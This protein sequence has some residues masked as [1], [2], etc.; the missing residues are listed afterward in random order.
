M[1][2][3][4]SDVTAAAPLWRSGFRPFFLAAASYAVLLMAAWM[5][6]RLGPALGLAYDTPAWHGHEAIFGFV[7]ATTAGFLL[8]ALPSWA[9]TPEIAGHRLAFLTLLWL[10]G[11][12]VMLFPVPAPWAAAVDCLFFP[13]L[14]ALL[15]PGVL[16]ATDRRY[17]LVLV[18][19]AGFAVGNLCYHGGRLVGDVE[20]E[21]LGIRIGYY[22]LLLLFSFVGGLLTPIFTANAIKTSPA[23]S[24]AL[25]W[26]APASLL[27][28][29]VSDLA[30]APA[31]PVVTAALV[32][33]LVHA[34]RMGGWHGW[35][36]RREP[37]LA[38]MHLGYLGLVLALLLSAVAALEPYW[39]GAAVHAF[40][41]GGLGLMKLSIMTRVALKHTGRP[42][43]MPQ[44][45]VIGMAMIAVAAAL[46]IL[47][48]VDVAREPLMFAAAVLWAAPF[49]AYLVL[50]AP[51]LLRPSIRRPA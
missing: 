28:L 17:R 11:R 41:V 42:V 36:V 9:G 26:L 13:A 37:I 30:G 1:R 8:T 27:V 33:A 48:G 21:M 3:A 22:I 29:A 19:L 45:L 50:Y 24:P 23:F 40:T 31:V 15:W 43:V 6:A 12:G 4:G 51:V 49:A 16:A 34:I 10:A 46:R 18:V 25:E 39:R 47:A 35:R 32:A 20:Y 44:V 38:A 2:L 5:A 7:A 14:A